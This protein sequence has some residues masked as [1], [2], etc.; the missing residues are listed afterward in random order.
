MHSPPNADSFEPRLL[1]HRLPDTPTE[2]SQL[3]LDELPLRIYWKN[4]N[5]VYLGCN[6]PVARDAGLNHPKDLIGKTDFDLPWGK[7]HAVAYRKEDLS[8]MYSGKPKVN[9]DEEQLLSDGSIRHMETT[10]KPLYCEA[11]EIVGV[12]GIT[13]LITEKKKAEQALLKARDAAEVANQM[14]REFISTMSHEIRSPMNVILGYIDLLSIQEKDAAKK[15]TLKTMTTNGQRLREIID[16]V[17]D[18]GKIESDDFIPEK[19]AFDPVKVFTRHF[20]AMEPLAAERGIGYTA[21][22]ADNLPQSVMSDPVRWGQIIRNLLS[23]AIKF[24][25][26]GTVK[27]T[28]SAT[29]TTDIPCGVRL[30]LTVKDTGIGMNAETLGQ[31]F[32]KFYR[33]DNSI[34]REFPGTGLGLCISRKIARILGGDVT[35]ATTWEDKGSTFVAS[36]TCPACPEVE[37]PPLRHEP[38]TSNSLPDLEIIAVDDLPAN[39]LLVKAY[40]KQIG[41]PCTTFSSAKTALT[42]INKN[43]VDVILMD[44]EMPKMNGLELTREIRDRDMQSALLDR[45]IHIIAMTAG[46][47]PEERQRCFDAGMNDYLSK[48]FNLAEL[49]TTLAKVTLD[50][51]TSAGLSLAS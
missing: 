24:T 3:V 19:V 11:G 40:L 29:P 13:R 31:L 18:I 17:F 22:I 49:T 8:V 50:A 32:Q 34:G 12:L 45:D 5:G 38:D 33:S 28:L 4:P 20:E 23:N 25:P 42:H 16:D 30:H 6:M 43:N 27:A 41:L 10:K 46:V 51:E 44:I 37:S 9:F 39:L 36:I 7:A 21:E 14:K 1:D 47:L 35:V 2:L 48:P 15:D 26:K